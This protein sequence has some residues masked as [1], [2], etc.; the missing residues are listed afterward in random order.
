M[1]IDTWKK[2]L[3]YSALFFSI[4]FA[5]IKLFK[6]EN[7]PYQLSVIAIFQNEGRFL[8]EWLDFYRVLGV[9]HF[10]LFNNLSED[11]YEEVLKPYIKAGLV[12]LYDWPYVSQP[13]NESDWTAIQSA[14]YRK[15]LELANGKSKWVAL[16]D[17]DEF[18]FP[19][20]KDNLIE[21]LKDY[22]ECSGLLINWQL[23]G[24]SHV[25]RIPDH[26]LMIETLL[27]QSP[28]Q[29]EVNKNCKSIVRPEK[30]K[31]CTNPHSV[32]YYAWTYSVD[33]DKKVFFG[34]FHQSRPVNIE[35]IRINHYW[36]RD[37]EFF[38]T[39]KLARNKNWGNK[40]QACVQINEEANQLINTEI[41][42]WV[43]RI[44]QLQ[45]NDPIL[46]PS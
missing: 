39:N 20:Q 35:K 44:R 10:Y 46:L 27:M 28:I 14:A 33:P 17:T 37:E 9:E 5:S 29:A 16:V 45:K 7:Y 6:K 30:V 12:E 15:G 32:V 21:F 40:K 34:D 3:L 38:Y 31:Y 1:Q 24:T 42:L 4:A 22:E 43:P 26:Q 41:L 23:F 36:P 8:K 19:K 2:M 18:M 13:G 25:A 11:N